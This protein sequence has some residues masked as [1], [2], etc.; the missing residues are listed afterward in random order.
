MN[1]NF[2][3]KDLNEEKIQFYKSAVN[4]CNKMIEHYTYVIEDISGEIYNSILNAKKGQ[5]IIFLKEMRSEWEKQKDVYVNT[6][7]QLERK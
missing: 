4:A 5:S 6:I 7:K 3:S 2:T 1:N